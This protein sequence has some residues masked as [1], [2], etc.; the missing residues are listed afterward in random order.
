[1]YIEKYTECLL[2]N[3]TLLTYLDD[4]IKDILNSAA[5]ILN[6]IRSLFEQMSESSISEKVNEDLRRIVEKYE[7]SKIKAF[8]KNGIRKENM[9][10]ISVDEFKQFSTVFE[11]CLRTV[12]ETS[13]RVLRDVN[14][15]SSFDKFVSELDE[16]LTYKLVEITK[17]ISSVIN[18]LTKINAEESFAIISVCNTLSVNNS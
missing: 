13:N 11:S 2:D 15:I 16:H 5:G 10:N 14:S 3:C 18:N 9:R 6:D 17:E 8:T 4:E 12:A 7:K 1:M